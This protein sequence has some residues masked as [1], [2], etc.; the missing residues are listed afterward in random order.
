MKYHYDHFAK[1]DTLLKIVFQRSEITL[2][3]PEDGELTQEGWKITPMSYPSVS[4]KSLVNVVILEGLGFESQVDPR[5][6]S[7]DFNPKNND[8]NIFNPV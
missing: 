3:I 8:N 5:I 7:L 1:W 4:C 2:D 6:F